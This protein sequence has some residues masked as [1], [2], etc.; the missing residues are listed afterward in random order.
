M[1]L[2]IAV[3]EAMMEKHGLYYDA[4]RHDSNKFGI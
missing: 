3:T 4:Y 2:D 1:K